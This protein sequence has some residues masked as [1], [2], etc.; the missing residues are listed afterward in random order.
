MKFFKVT[1]SWMVFWTTFKTIRGE[2]L[3]VEML[4]QCFL[5][6][7]IGFYVLRHNCY[8]SSTPREFES[9]WLQI[10][11]H[12]LDPFFVTLDKQVCFW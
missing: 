8:S 12:L 9:V 7:W 1:F 3:L 11:Q 6:L 2:L 5:S 4:A 10:D